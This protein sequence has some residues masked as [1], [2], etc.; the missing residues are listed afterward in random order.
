VDLP[1]AT[2]LAPGAE[3]RLVVHGTFAPCTPGQSPFTAPVP[4]V[5]VT[6]RQLGIQRTQVV[7]AAGHAVVHSC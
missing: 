7:T 2:D 1:K 3:A 6:F 5:E 4:G